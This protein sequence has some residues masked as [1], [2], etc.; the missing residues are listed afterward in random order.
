MKIKINAFKSHGVRAQARN[1]PEV[2]DK[3]LAR[4]H[5]IID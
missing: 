4:Y 3:D 5:S 1:W 2:S